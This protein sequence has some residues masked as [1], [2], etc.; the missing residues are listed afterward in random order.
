MFV[1]LAK[2]SRTAQLSHMK[3]ASVVAL[4]FFR[5]VSI[6]VNFLNFVLAELRIAVHCF[7]I[8]KAINFDR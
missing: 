2:G 4:I 5:S 6:F 3:F 8:E 1:R 7:S